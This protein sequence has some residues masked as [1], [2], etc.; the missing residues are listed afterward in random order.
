MLLIYPA[1]GLH[2][3]QVN[4]SYLFFCKCLWLDDF[5]RFANGFR[6]ALVADH[7]SLSCTYEFLILGGSS[8]IHG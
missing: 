8:E 2:S 7:M 3:L 5:H 6:F 1:L 4:E